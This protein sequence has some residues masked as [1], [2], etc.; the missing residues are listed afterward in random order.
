MDT[1]V[2]MVD[3]SGEPMTTDKLRDDLR[4][5]A[6]DMERFLEATAGETRQRVGEVR[7]RAEESL[8][9]A[10]TRLASLQDAALAR[11]RYA[12]R[13]TDRYVHANPWQVIAAGVA[14]G[15]ALG[16]LLMHNERPEP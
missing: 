1:K 14:A 2:R 5:L 12:G 13:E 6:G 15:V 7:S 16:I 11:A 4:V 8:K 3:T 10:R 9:A